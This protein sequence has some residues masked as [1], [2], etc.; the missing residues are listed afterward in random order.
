MPTQGLCNHVRLL[1]VQAKV[2]LAISKL[3][4][5]GQSDMCLPQESTASAPYM[6]YFSWGVLHIGS[7]AV[8]T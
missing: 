1:V 4:T 8:L 7:L 5:G 3:Q 6:Y 2:L